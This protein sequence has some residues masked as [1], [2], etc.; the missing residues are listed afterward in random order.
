M[1]DVDVRFFFILRLEEITCDRISEGGAEAWH[2]LISEHS[3]LDS[4]DT[5]FSF[6]MLLRYVSS[7]VYNTGRCIRLIQQK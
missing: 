7:K 6:A 2:P 5:A 3:C 4:L 1:I